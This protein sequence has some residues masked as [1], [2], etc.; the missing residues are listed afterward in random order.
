MRNKVNKVDPEITLSTLLDALVH[1]LIDASDE[2]I[3]ETAKDLKMSLAVKESAAFAG[4]LYPSRLK[5]EDFFDF[6]SLRCLA[7]S[8]RRINYRLH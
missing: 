4:L 5:V 2:E 7:I 1:E 8:R 3:Q 6:E